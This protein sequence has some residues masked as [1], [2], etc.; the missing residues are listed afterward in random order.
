MFLASNS[1]ASASAGPLGELS[2]REWNE[3]APCKSLARVSSKK[4]SA[5]SQR[6]EKS[7]A[8]HQSLT[9]LVGL[10]SIFIIATIPPTINLS[11]PIE[12]SANVGG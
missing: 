1:V 9:Q 7:A 10:I 11:F 5:H 3:V 2:N 12:K 8:G 6:L 4:S